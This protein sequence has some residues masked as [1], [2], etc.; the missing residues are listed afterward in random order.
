MCVSVSV[1]VCGGGGGGVL[2]G[3]VLLH[4]VVD[5]D[6]S[7][8]TLSGDGMEHSCSVKI[9]YYSCRTLK[10]TSLL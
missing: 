8:V 6:K 7:P 3:S 9:C 5:K 2:S 10:R 4:C 1:C